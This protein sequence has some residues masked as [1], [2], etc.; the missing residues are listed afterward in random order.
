MAAAGGNGTRSARSY[1]PCVI[2]LKAEVGPGLSGLERVEGER[3]RL[4]DPG[5]KPSSYK[6]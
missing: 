1:E 5:R 6:R 4:S 3:L 2:F